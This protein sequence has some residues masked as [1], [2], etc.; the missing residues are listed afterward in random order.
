MR[1]ATTPAACET[2]W[3]GQT[4]VLAQR[5]L[6]PRGRAEQDTCARPW[7]HENPRVSDAVGAESGMGQRSAAR[8]PQSPT[9]LPTRLSP[10][11]GRHLHA[12]K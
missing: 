1:Q 11:R 8:E 10:T 3:T 6:V 12:R 7:G 9:V 5:G 4:S 2:I